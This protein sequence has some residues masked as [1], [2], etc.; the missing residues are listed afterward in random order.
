[1]LAKMFDCRCRGYEALDADA[2]RRDRQK[3]ALRQQHGY[4]VLRFLAEDVGKH[5]DPVL[6]TVLA[7]LAHRRCQSALSPLR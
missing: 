1:M 7:A 3:D 5:L 2:Y 6:D 4:F